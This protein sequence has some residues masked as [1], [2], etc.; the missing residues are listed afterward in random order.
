M[1]RVTPSGKRLNYPFEGKI[2]YRPKHDESLVEL[3]KKAGTEYLIDTRVNDIVENTVIL[4]N[5]KEIT[6]KI[7]VGC[8]GPH[9]PLRK[10]FWKEN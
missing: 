3:A 10:K 7:I 2:L 9:D 4:N 1:G 8:G 6:A 5:G